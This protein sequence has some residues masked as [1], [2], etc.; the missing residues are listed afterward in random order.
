MQYVQTN[1]CSMYVCDIVQLPTLILKVS[2]FCKSKCYLT[3]Y[4]T[5]YAAELQ[6]TFFKLFSG[7]VGLKA[8]SVLFSLKIE[9]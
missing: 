4:A 1:V 9:K 8:F 5:A 3:K 7:S 6:E 2:L